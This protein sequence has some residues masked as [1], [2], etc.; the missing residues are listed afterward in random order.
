MP[1]P[2]D[3][4]PV[5]YGPGQF[6]NGTNKSHQALHAC[7]QYMPTHCLLRYIGM[8]PCLVLEQVRTS[9]PRQAGKGFLA[10]DSDCYYSV[11]VDKR[12]LQGQREGYTRIR[13]AR[14]RGDAER[15]ANVRG[16]CRHEI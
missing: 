16:R 2:S 15:V 7:I 5:A 11:A 1:P 3:S 10:S 6:P 13:G 4:R 14:R 8:C 9:E 12:D